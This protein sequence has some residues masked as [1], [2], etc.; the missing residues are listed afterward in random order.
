MDSELKK[1]D[2]RRSQDPE[3]LELK[4]WR[5]FSTNF[6]FLHLL[7]D[8][9]GPGLDLSVP[10]FPFPLNRNDASFYLREPLEGFDP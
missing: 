6:W 3:I 4:S 2:L 7:A 8:V 9:T 1:Q 5:N 10:Q